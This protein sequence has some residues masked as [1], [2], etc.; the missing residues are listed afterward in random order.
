MTNQTKKLVVYSFPTRGKVVDATEYINSHES[1][2]VVRSAVLARADNDEVTIYDNDITPVEGAVTGGTLGAIMGT[3]GL[4]SLGAL[5]L[6]GIGPLVALG[7]GAVAG[8]AIGGGLG[9]SAARLMDFGINDHVLETLAHHLHRNEAAL[10]LELE[11]GEADLNEMTDRLVHE[12]DAE[13]V[14][15]EKR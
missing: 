14:P 3:M 8:G 11:G 9:A 7:L 10:A 2:K 6:P 13:A 4:A 15:L 1:V 12:F 5:L